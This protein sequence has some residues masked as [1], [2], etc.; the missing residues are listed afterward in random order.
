MT[1]KLMLV[2][3]G[4]LTS[5]AWD[6][7]LPY[8]RGPARAIDLPGR[9]YNPADLGAVTRDDWVEAVVVALQDEPPGSVVL[10]GHSSAGYIMAEAAARV[11]ERLTH[12]VF[13]AATVPADGS[14]PVDYIKP[15]LQELAEAGYE[16]VHAMTTGRTLG[17]LRP[18][19]PPISTTLE[20]V[21]NGPRMGLE[22]Q[23][24]LFA[25]ASGWSD[26]PPQ[27]PRTF[28]RCT[29]DR[30]VTPELVERMLP[31]MGAV[32][33]ID[34]SA[35]HDVSHEAPEALASV[36]NQVAGEADAAAAP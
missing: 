7:V 17:G 8:L 3:G 32:A 27:L 22:A 26:V 20:I 33:V 4:T 15:R 19:E 16:T 30:V 18:G 6:P 12:L 23:G 14:R 31:H 9:R 10:V 1:A 11:P 2:H 13:V 21:E 24:P 28:L 29:N 25:V 5:T 35:G 34:I 36:L